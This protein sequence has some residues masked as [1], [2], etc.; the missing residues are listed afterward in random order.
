MGTRAFSNPICNRGHYHTVE[1]NHLNLPKSVY[2]PL[3]QI[4]SRL[5]EKRSVQKEALGFGYR[6]ERKKRELS[7]VR[8]QYL[9]STTHVHDLQRAP[10]ATKLALV[11]VRSCGGKLR[12]YSGNVRSLCGLSRSSKKAA[13]LFKILTALRKVCCE[14]ASIPV[15]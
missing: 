7:I 12:C 6:K 9:L 10:S 5:S 8:A 11:D 4:T 13:A 14:V 1:G 3:V 2:L 15:G